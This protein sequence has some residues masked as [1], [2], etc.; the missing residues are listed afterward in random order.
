MISNQ[1]SANIIPGATSSGIALLAGPH[2]GLSQ[3]AGQA[4]AAHL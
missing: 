2:F 4:L 3:Q 1:L